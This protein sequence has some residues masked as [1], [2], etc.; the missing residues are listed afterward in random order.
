[1]NLGSDNLNIP[2]QSKQEFYLDV[3]MT[4]GMRML[5]G[6]VYE[7]MEYIERWKGRNKDSA[8]VLEEY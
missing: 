4:G 6:M 5:Y 8:V 2:T 3:F 1:M 7:G